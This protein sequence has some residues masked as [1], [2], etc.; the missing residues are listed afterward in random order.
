MYEEI[1]DIEYDFDNNEICLWRTKDNK[2]YWEN[3]SIAEVKD[4]INELIREIARQK[5]LLEKGE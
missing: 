3:L 1:N 4:L 2:S 5:N